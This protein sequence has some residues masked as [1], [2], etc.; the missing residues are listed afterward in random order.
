MAAG[1]FQYGTSTALNLT[2]ASLANSATVGWASDA[3]DNTVN[4]YV[5]AILQVR[6]RLLAGAT[7][8]D[9]LVYVYIYGSEDG[10]Q[11]TDA[12]TG[13]SASY[14][15]RSPTALVLIQTIPVSGSNLIFIGAPIPLSSAHFGVMP[16]KWGVFLRN[17]SGLSF[18]ATETDHR[19]SYTG[20]KISTV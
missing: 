19:V 13:T 6:F 2:L 17:F 10:A 11:F 8:N 16:R 18:T 4:N 7:A 1:T 5:D 20:I 3:V 14:T 15:M 12:V 9:Q